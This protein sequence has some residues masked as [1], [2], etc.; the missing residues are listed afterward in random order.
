MTTDNHKKQ[1]SAALLTVILMVVL[2]LSCIASLLLGAVSI[3]LSDVIRVVQMHFSPVTNLNDPSYFIIIEVR[4]PRIIMTALAG[5]VLSLVGVL[6]QTIAQNPLAEP[7]V[8]GI[9]S[10]ASAGAVSAIVLGWFSFFS[11]GNVFIGAFFG[12]L[13]AIFIVIVLQSG[14]TS[15]VRLVLVGIGV[16]AFFQALTTMIIYS[17][18]N[19]AQVRS[20]MFWTVGS[21]SGVQWDDLGFPFVLLILLIAFSLISSKELDL[22]LLGQRAA[23]QM[24]LNIRRFQLLVVIVSSA[25]VAIIVAK[26]GVIGFVGLIVP[27]IMR[28]IS[29]VRHR[30]LIMH[31]TLCGAIFLVLTDTVA[32]T[33]FA[34]QEIPIG[35]ITALLGAPVFIFM[36]RRTKSWN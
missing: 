36:I 23:L 13:A 24:G 33:I 12:S 21:F 22:L 1:F 3:E 7:Y 26:V 4:I 9:S 19:E 28:K 31:T 11:S 35:I 8:L 2:V 20:A 15:P 16:S 6:M 29:G 25:A 27:H 5:A 32:R 10:G 34:P 30:A 18:S 17:S 14:S